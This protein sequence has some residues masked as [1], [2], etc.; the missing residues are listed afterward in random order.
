MSNEKKA[1]PRT[2]EGAFEVLE[3]FQNQIRA[4]QAVADVH[5]VMLCTLIETHPEKPRIKA[6]WRA[7]N[8]Q[9]LAE[10]ATDADPA[11][12][13]AVRDTVAGFNLRLG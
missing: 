12:A 13:A 5:L 3:A 6:L 1:V 4:N 11:Y 8:A 9:L 2:I 7:G 10:M